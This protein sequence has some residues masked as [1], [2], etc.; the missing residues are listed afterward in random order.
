MQ[1]LD[2]RLLGYKEKSPQLSLDGRYFNLVVGK[3]PYVVTKPLIINIGEVVDSNLAHIYLNPLQEIILLRVI[4]QNLNTDGSVLSRH[5]NLL[6]IDNSLNDPSQEAIRRFE[7]LESN[8]YSEYV[9]QYLQGQF[10]YMLP[11]HQY[12]ELNYHPQPGSNSGLCVAYVLKFAYYYLLNQP[13]VFNGESDILQFAMYVEKL[14]SSKLRGKPDI[15]YGRGSVLGGAAIGG[16]TGGLI[17]GAV[18]GPAGAVAGFGLG[19]LGGATLGSV[20]YR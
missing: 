5:S 16:L 10:Q 19:A 12:S 13:I 20:S 8:V 14:Y 6:I 9:N 4:I 2:T 15:E 11:Q 18:G 17:G 1:K 7:P 3:H